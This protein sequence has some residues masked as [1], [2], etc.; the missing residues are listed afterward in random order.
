MLTYSPVSFASPEPPIQ[1]MSTEGASAIFEEYQKEYDTV[2]ESISQKL[3]S[4]PSVAAEQK[5]LLVSQ[6]KRELEEADEIISQMEMELLSLPGPIRSR[7][8]PR[9]KSY[10]DEIKKFEK[11][12]NR[13]T[14]VSGKSERDQLLG[15]GGSHIVDVEAAGMDQRS[16]LLQG[17]ERLQG[18]SRKLDD[19][20]RLALETETSGISTLESLS[21]QRE[22][23]QRTRNTLTTA[24]GFIS[25]SQGILRGMQRRMATNKLITAGIIILMILLI[26][27]IV[28]AKWFS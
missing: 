17:T 27:L 9:V 20:R 15:T 19:A 6:T 21:R 14:A 8:Q 25:K 2:H 23:I 10:K 5:K 16:R 12:L 18:A 4:V 13:T 26:V 7:L 1:N 28:W 22:Q 24:D 3:A 11:E